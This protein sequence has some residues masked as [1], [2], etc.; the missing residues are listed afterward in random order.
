MKSNLVNVALH[1]N[2]EPPRAEVRTVEDSIS[3]REGKDP[4]QVPIA[5][6]ILH[7]RSSAT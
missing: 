7:R 5:R 4:F 2:V 3:S 1:A 6:Q